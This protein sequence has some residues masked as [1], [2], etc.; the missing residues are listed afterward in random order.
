[1][2]ECDA[3]G[4]VFGGGNEC[5][6]CGGRIHHVAPENVDDGRDGR[7]SGPLPGESALNEAIQGVSG[8][9]LSPIENQSITQS[10]LPFQMGGSSTQIGSSLPFGI[11]APSNIGIES[12]EDVEA[13]IEVSLE[14]LPPE[15]VEEHLP[16]IAVQRDPVP[17]NV[18][19]EK[20]SPILVARV[21]EEPIVEEQL[22]PDPTLVDNAYSINA[23]AFDASQVYAVEDDVVIH[24]FGDELQV[25]EVIV[26]FDEL[27]DPAEQTVHFD[28]MLLAEG[29]PELLPARALPI[30]DEGDQLV[31]TTIGAGFVALGDGRWSD[32]ADRF[33]DVCNARPGDSAALNDFGLALLQ[34]AIV[35]HESNPTSTPAEEPH[36]ENAVLALRQAAQ[37][38]KH[39]PTI[40]YNLATCLASCGRHGVATRIWDAAMTLAPQDPAPMNGKAVSLIA[41]GEIDAATG[42]LSRA[43]ELAPNEP[44]ITRNLMRLKPMA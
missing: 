15:S 20:P 2:Q 32:A 19:D 4:L 34:Q 26:N 9:D 37:Q 43:K 40:M 41:L 3:C 14:S 6:S 31:A 5:P 38:D 35:I 33:R 23:E 25:S 11:G 18:V 36:F 30:E 24:D 10:S 42:Q 22:S 29:D 8:V 21:V 7:L 1:M 16:T 28:P 27:V 12:D 17:M 13:S 44:V 39:N